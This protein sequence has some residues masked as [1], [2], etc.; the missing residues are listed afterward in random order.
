MESGVQGQAPLQVAG[1]E[2]ASRRRILKTRIRK[3]AGIFAL[4]RSPIVSL[5]LVEVASKECHHFT[6]CPWRPVSSRQ[7]GLCITEEEA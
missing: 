2:M 3:D 6:A 1:V 7:F 5:D 4:T